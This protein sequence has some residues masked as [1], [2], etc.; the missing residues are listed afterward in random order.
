MERESPLHILYLV[1]A[2]V[3]TTHPITIT[4]LTILNLKLELNLL[5]WLATLTP[6]RSL[7]TL[8]KP[9]LTRTTKEDVRGG[10][11]EQGEGD[12]GRGGIRAKGD[13]FVALV[14]EG[15]GG[16]NGRIKLDHGGSEQE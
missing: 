6:F 8:F 7:R 4:S 15:G 14:A 13:G 10:G 11:R 5:P 3:T 1:A 9:V 2:I 16:D 12:G